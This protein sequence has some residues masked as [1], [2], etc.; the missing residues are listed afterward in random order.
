MVN[1]P[2]VRSYFLGKVAGGIGRGSGSLGS[3]KPPGI[4]MTVESDSGMIRR[5]LLGSYLVVAAAILITCYL[6]D[7]TKIQIPNKT[8]QTLVL[9]GGCS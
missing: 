4:A 1:S 8:Y 6:E 9:M 3:P 2:L 5:W 7:A